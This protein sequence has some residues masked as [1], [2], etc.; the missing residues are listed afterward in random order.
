MENM[1]LRTELARLSEECKKLTSDHSSLLVSTQCHCFHCSNLFLQDFNS[2]WLDNFEVSLSVDC[3]PF[4]FELSSNFRELCYTWLSPD[5]KFCIAPKS[6]VLELI[7]Y[8]VSKE[9]DGCEVIQLK[10]LL[11]VSFPLPH[12]WYLSL[13][14]VSSLAASVLCSL[15][16]RRINILTWS[17]THVLCLGAQR[18][19][20]SVRTMI[21]PLI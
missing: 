14:L 5:T 15:S 9:S 10:I 1:A 16:G 3:L 18:A 13:S 2:V 17:P 20:Q 21:N 6:Y 7:I 8:D 11:A 4:S 19:R 12:H